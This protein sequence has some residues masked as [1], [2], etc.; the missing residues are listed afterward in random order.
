MV[1]A[2]HSGALSCLALKEDGDGMDL[3]PG[4]AT[5]LFGNG[6]YDAFPVIASR[7]DVVLATWRSAAEHVNDHSSY[8]RGA[9]STDGGRTYGAPFVL[10]DDGDPLIEI[11]MGGLAWDE[12]RQRWVLLLLAEHF[13][14]ATTATVQR[15]SAKVITSP[16]LATGS[17]WSQPSLDLPLSA[18]SWWF[19]CALSASPDGMW[20]AVGYGVMAGETQQRP[21]TLTSRDAG[22][23][24]SPLAPLDAP[25]DLK[26]SEA[27][28]LRLA[29]GTWLMT[30]R[31]DSD[32]TIHTATSD[33]GVTWTY[34]G[35]VLG[36]Y[37]GFPATGQASDGTIVMLLRGGSNG[38]DPVHGKWAW[39]WSQ[40][41]G[42]SWS[43]R[44][45]FPGGNRAMM[46]G[47]LAQT[48]DGNLACVFASEDDPDQPWKSS[49]VYWMR[50]TIDPLTVKLEW[51]PV[52][53]GVAVPRVAI[54][55]AGMLSVDRV[56]GDA[57]SGEDIVEGVRFPSAVEQ[58][59][60]W[61]YELQQGQAATYTTGERSTGA[62]VMPILSGPMLIHPTQPELSLRVDVLT[63]DSRD[64]PIDTDVT[65][66]PAAAGS[67]ERPQY[68]IV[69]TSGMLG[70]Y[71]GSTKIRTRTLNEERRLRRCVAGLS[72]LF[73]SHHRGLGFPPWI[74]ITAL[75]WDRFVNHCTDPLAS[76]DDDD[77]MSQWRNWTIKWVE[78][79][80][81]SPTM[82]RPHRRIRDVNRPFDSI[83]ATIEDS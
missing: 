25:A 61:D 15:R 64:L 78:Q 36:G 35:P 1:H 17:S 56:V 18:A 10:Y 31:C 28:I 13:V 24:W 74:R 29:S 69:S 7:G 27:P 75:T 54:S 67:D 6:R 57:W 34:A 42:A 71:V 72:P 81:P 20:V 32:T 21:I 30:I 53:P 3:I 2:K 52:S 45:D 22:K 47:G 9:L 5:K 49:S 50:Y 44:D 38:P 70:S 4:R 82:L 80:R 68:P 12:S 37:S 14:N 66:V 46:Y 79:E 62:V 59:T 26:L 83:A 65:A 55:G 8:V 16:L 48:A 77:D 23:S 60:W 76:W 11:S 19:G 73:F 40:D 58:G 43:T 41:D 33:D 39:A 51:L 63:D